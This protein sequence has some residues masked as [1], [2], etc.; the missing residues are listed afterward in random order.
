MGVPRLV[1]SNVSLFR[2]GPHSFWRDVFGAYR[3]SRTGMSP[4]VDPQ[5]NDGSV[6]AQNGFSAHAAELEAK[7]CSVT[8]G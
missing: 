7:T 2:T 4:R 8:Q 3:K 5:D 1:L 6:P